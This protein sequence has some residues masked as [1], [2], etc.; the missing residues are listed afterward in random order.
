MFPM[1]TK[2][3]LNPSHSEQMEYNLSCSFVKGRKIYGKLMKNYFF[4]F[5]LDSFLFT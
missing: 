1:N 5:F 2:K 3:F 4:I